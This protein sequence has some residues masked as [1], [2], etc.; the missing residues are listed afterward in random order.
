MNT[1]IN[2]KKCTRDMHVWYDANMCLN[3]TCYNNSKLINTSMFSMV[4]RGDYKS[5]FI[6]LSRY[7]SLL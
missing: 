5:S 1:C 4:T 3:I 2:K 6:L 7:T